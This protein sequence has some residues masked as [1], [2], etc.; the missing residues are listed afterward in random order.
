MGVRTNQ[1]LWVLELRG[2]NGSYQNRSLVGVSTMFHGVGVRTNQG[3]WLG[4]R[5]C[6]WVLELINGCGWVLELIKGCG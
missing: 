5:T 2:M 4:I 3:L 6:E 1:G